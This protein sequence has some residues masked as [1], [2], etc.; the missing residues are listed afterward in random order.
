MPPNKL[1]F[2]NE[3]SKVAGYKINIQCFYTM[4]MNYKKKINLK[5]NFP[6]CHIKK[7]K[8]PRNRSRQEGKKSVL[9]KL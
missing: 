9:R 8:I 1:E 4:I 2:I 3:F 5:N 6:H 7:N